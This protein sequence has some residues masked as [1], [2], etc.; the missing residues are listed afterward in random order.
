MSY[1]AAVPECPQWFDSCRKVRGANRTVLGAGVPLREVAK[2]VPLCLMKG[3]P[4]VG[5]VAL[6]SIHPDT[7]RLI[8]Y[9]RVPDPDRSGVRGRDNPH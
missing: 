6:L 1:A 2:P 8:G 9:W 7:K 4:D 5:R 3:I